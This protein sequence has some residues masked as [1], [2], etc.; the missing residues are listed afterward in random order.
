M[1]SWTK[2]PSNVPASTKPT[3]GTKRPHL[4]FQLWRAPPLPPMPNPASFATANLPSL[5][6][7]GPQTSTSVLNAPCTPMGMKDD[8]E[9]AAGHA[10]SPSPDFP[11][12]KASMPMQAMAEMGMDVGDM[13]G[14]SGLVGW[15]REYGLGRREEPGGMSGLEGM[16]GLG[17]GLG[18]MAGLG[19]LGDTGRMGGMGIGR[20]LNERVDNM[21]MTGGVGVDT[22]MDD[23]P[24]RMFQGFLKT[25]KAYDSLDLPLTP[26]LKPQPSDGSIRIPGSSGQPTMPTSPGTDFNMDEVV[27]LLDSQNS[28]FQPYSEEKAARDTHS[29]L[30]GPSQAS[31]SSLFAAPSYSSPFSNVPSDNDFY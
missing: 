10:P 21:G 5:T 7:S 9:R 6:T 24:D 12:S 22:D 16:G 15:Y 18:E 4:D 11:P 8:T 14:V 25:H 3:I 20:R 29:D 2:P 31:G 30:A 19:G 23:D 26:G 1:T 17:M 13:G 28:V 27:I